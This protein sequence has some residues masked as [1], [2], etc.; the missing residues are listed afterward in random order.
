MDSSTIVLN[1]S[2]VES[3][4][5]NGSTV[6]VRFSKAYIVKTMT[7]AFQK[8][9]W[10]QAGDLVFEG[11]ELQGDIPSFPAVCAG[12]DVGENIYTYRDMVPLP[13]N[14]RG[15]AHCKLK[16]RDTDQLLELTAVAVDL[17]MEG[18]PRYIEHF[19]DDQT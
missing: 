14:S 6:T 11:A 17:N 9:R 8:T 10:Y 1:G 15:H 19:S 3:I 16:F 4:D 12:G 7:G 18:T 2:E 5:I 13:L